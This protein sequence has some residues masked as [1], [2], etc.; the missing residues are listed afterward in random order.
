MEPNKLGVRW[1]GDFVDS[2][3]VIRIRDQFGGG[4]WPQFLE[5][6]EISG[7]RGWN[8]QSVQFRFP[9]TAVCGENGTGKSTVL[10]VAASAYDP[11]QGKGYFPSDF[12]LSTHWDEISNVLLI[13][14]I[15]RGDDVNSFS[16]KKPSKRW[17]FPEVRYQRNVFWFDV[18]RTLPL[19]ASAGYSRV[20]K[21]AAGEVSTDELAVESRESLSSILGREY[22]S[23]RFAAPDVNENRKVGL[24]GRDYGEISQFHQG[25]G[26]DTT[27]DLIHA[28]QAVPDHSLVIIDEVEASLHPR[29][30]RRLARYL[31]NQSRLKRLQVIVS[32]HSPY[33]LE[34]LP[35]EAR[36]LLLPGPDGPNIV[37]GASPEFALSRIDDSVH[38]EA[39]VYVEDE[40]AGIWLREIVACA[41]DGSDLLARIKISPVGP[42]N[43]VALMGRLGASGRLPHAS[44]GV[45]DG[46]AD[47]SEGCARLPGDTAPERVVLGALRDAGWPHLDERFGIGAG[48]LFQHLEDAVLTADHH[49]WTRLIG[50]RVTKSARSVWETLAAEWC[51]SCL[52]EADRDALIGKI[53]TVLP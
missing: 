2:P 11:K 39:F 40:V 4:L 34:E 52:I 1:P 6:V 18:A 15:R 51:R 33:I 46:D 10:K 27:L 41:P 7:L 20:A 22:I 36:V 38:P 5:R 9:V 28:L 17:S 31:L 26:E 8:G 43:V 19:D 42:A 49:Q 47:E 12:F 45:L 24:L 50:D 13:Y 37:Y 48:T 25:A 29:A 21:L 32:T 30:Q 14:R 16:I 44:L 23:A 3:E 35:T 53:D